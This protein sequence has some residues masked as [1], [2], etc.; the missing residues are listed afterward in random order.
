MVLYRFDLEGY[1]YGAALPIDITWCG[2]NY[3]DGQIHWQVN[4]NWSCEQTG[5]KVSRY[6]QGNDLV[7]KFGLIGRYC[8]DFCLYY[9]LY[10]GYSL[11]NAR[12][13]SFS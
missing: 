10:G 12:I 4:K 11:F 2:Y 7:L 6:Y 3:I 9:G 1:A 13:C 8:K 5:V